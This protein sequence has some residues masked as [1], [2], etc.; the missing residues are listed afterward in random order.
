MVSVMEGALLY[1]ADDSTIENSEYS[2]Y[3]KWLK[4]KYGLEFNSHQALWEWSTTETEAFW[5]SIWEYGNIVHSKP[6][7]SVL[8]GEKM[9]FF[10]WFQN[11]HLNYVDQ[12][13][14]HKEQKGPAI[15]YKSENQ[16]TQSITWSQ[17]YEDVATLAKY[18]KSKGIQKGDRVVAY[19]PNIPE[20]V[21]S[22]LACASI[23]AIWAVAS[24]DFGLNSV[25]DR[26]KQVEPKL[27]IAVNGYQYNGKV[28]E[29]LDT[30]QHLLE[31]I[32]SIEHC[33]IIQNVGE[34]PALKSSNTVHWEDALKD[35]TN[36]I[37]SE[38]VEFSH[39]LW[40]LYS[41]GTTG[42][43]KPIVHSHG[44]IIVE[45]IKTLQI[46]ADLGK[47]DR[48]FWFTTTGW[49]MW[50]ILVS[51]L[52]TGSTIVLYDGSPSYPNLSALWAYA[53]EVGITVFG[54]S[55]PFIDICF[56][57]NFQPN[58][59]FKFP[60]LRTV[61]STGSPLSAA[62]FKWV[63]DA[64]KRD[65]LLV[66]IS[67]GTDVC[68]GFIG[69]NIS[70]PVRAG[71]LPSRSLG[72]KA[73]S[74]DEEGNSI[75][76]SVG[77][78]VITKP[79]PSMPIYFW[80]DKE[81]SRYLDSYFSNYPNVWRHGDWIQ[82]HEDGSCIIFGRSD[83]T[84]NRSGVRMGTSEIYKI[85]ESFPEI[86]DSLVV[87][88]EYKDRPTC[89]SLFIVMQ[90]PDKLND[91]FKQKICDAIRENL[92]P[93]FVPDRIHVIQEVPKTLN[94]KKLEV[95]V[96][97]ILLGMPVEKSINRDAMANPKSLDYFIE[98]SKSYHTN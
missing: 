95:P 98:L 65:I 30:I 93:R 24:P 84:I 11:A 37:E 80:G 57:H 86:L 48:F 13:F 40:I 91:E 15:I 97:K 70:L 59:Y 8:S 69:G 27:L 64:V 76:G 74:Y 9:P 10:K 78:L 54:T 38:Q 41:S 26:F 67:G 44:G 83:A 19:A 62:C 49:M 94:G 43:P 85:V 51:G 7:D 20:T 88:L 39:P 56:K 1:Q 81:F 61:L 90:E 92:S 29:K 42:L 53:E 2:R 32:P 6:Y 50:N 66:S 25:V 4:E 45:H 35:R 82:I 89:L 96:R 16:K 28:Y 5:K 3:K 31:E 18:M 36:E 23:G 72:V 33:I 14:R 22:F 68:T 60:K 21:I 63:Y 77:E 71:I 12:V 47:D 46:E 34:K 52:M 87:D 17:L 79:M 55:A 75:I 58:S 73:E